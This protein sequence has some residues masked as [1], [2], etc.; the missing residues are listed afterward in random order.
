LGLVQDLYAVSKGNQAFLHSR[1][2]LGPDQLDRYKA[3]ISRWICPD[4]LSNPEGHVFVDWRADR[5]AVNLI[6][7]EK[8]GPTVEIPQRR[9]FGT[10]VITQ[11]LKSLSGGIVFS[12]DSDGVCCNIEFKS[13]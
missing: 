8:G 10:V 5:E 4:A 6:W 2:A 12:F 1:L 9:G 7:K 11:S 3:G 13:G